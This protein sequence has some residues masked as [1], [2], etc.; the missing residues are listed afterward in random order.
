M[1]TNLNFNKSD[2]YHFSLKENDHCGVI[3]HTSSTCSQRQCCVNANYHIVCLRSL[4]KSD[5][6]LLIYSKNTFC[7]GVSND[8]GSH[9]ETSSICAVPLGIIAVCI[10]R[11]VITLDLRSK[12]DVDGHYSK[13]AARILANPL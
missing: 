4:H 11:Y 6:H 7:Q 12:Y 10:Y 3:N 2:T 13:F 8:V 5:R 9:V 1:V